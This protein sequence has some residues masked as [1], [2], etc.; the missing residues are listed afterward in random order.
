MV[1]VPGPAAGVA[2]WIV[3][4]SA[5]A[6]T[7]ATAPMVTATAETPPA[8]RGARDSRVRVSARINRSTATASSTKATTSTPA[9]TAIAGISHT[10]TSATLASSGIRA[11]TT[12]WS[13]AMVS[14]PSEA[15]ITKVNGVV[16]VSGAMPSAIDVD[17]AAIMRGTAS[18]SVPVG[19]TPRS[20][21]RGKKTAVTAPAHTASSMSVTT[22]AAT[23]SRRST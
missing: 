23:R 18:T 22:V 10:A 11:V 14:S 1:A 8:R 7:I 2:A 3:G 12:T 21:S 4:P 19:M 6:V 17:A 13:S 5:R 16:A 9:G 20:A 15:T